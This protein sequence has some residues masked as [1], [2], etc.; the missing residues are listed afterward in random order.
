MYC[1]HS[2]DHDHNKN[3][4]WEKARN[5]GRMLKG[6]CQSHPLDACNVVSCLPTQSS[7]AEHLSI[8]SLW[9]R[10]EREQ[11]AKRRGGDRAEK[12]EERTLK[13]EQEENRRKEER[14]KRKE[15][16]KC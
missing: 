7:R 5:N 8:S 13:R 1:T 11:R 4:S 15:K 14:A 3:S 6:W 10:V 2:V 9:C 12:R 16:D